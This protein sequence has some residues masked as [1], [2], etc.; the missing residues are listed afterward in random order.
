MSDPLPRCA[1]GGRWVGWACCRAAGTSW[2]VPSGDASAPWAWQGAVR[3]SARAVVAWPRVWPS[4]AR[5]QRRRSYDRAHE[6]GSRRDIG[7]RRRPRTRRGGGPEGPGADPDMLRRRR[8]CAERR[9]GRDGDGPQPREPGQEALRPGPARRQVERDAPSRAGEA[10]RQPEQLP[11]Q[12]PRRDDALA[13]ADPRRPAR[14]VVRHHL[15]REPGPVGGE[16]P[17]RQVLE[18][19]ALLP[20][21]GWRSPPRRGGGDRPPAR[22]SHPPGR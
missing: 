7:L 4:L 10:S 9:S 15:D 13:Q 17:G 6:H 19:H 18:P 22:A 5:I 3:G 1:C 12:R 14:Q 2:A 21:P 8:G 16:A 20:G 11:A